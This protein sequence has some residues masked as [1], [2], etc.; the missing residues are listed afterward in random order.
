MR[1]E[2][3]FEMRYASERDKA[4]W[5]TLDD[6]ISER[7]LDL[8]IRDR[9]GY[10]ISD[11]R[12]PIGI[13]RYNLFWDTIPFVTLIYLDE[14]CRAKGFG[15]QAMLL[16]ESEM[17]ALGHKMVMTSTRV[18]EEAQHFYRALGYQDRGVLCLDHTPFAQPGELFLLKV[19]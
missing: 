1:G 18:D 14:S 2:R 17:R 12:N 11:N 4:F 7:E 3:V 5:L 19:L 13:L 15:R 6:H 10:V 16:W 8:K 9:R